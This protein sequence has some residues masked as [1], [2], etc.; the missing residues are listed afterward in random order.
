MEILSA[1]IILNE[2]NIKRVFI[3]VFVASK[4]IIIENVNA[5]NAIAIFFP[6]FVNIACSADG[7]QVTFA[8]A[9]NSDCVVARITSL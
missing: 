3:S 7:W 4:I 5:I 2:A 6:T 8:I 9:R 1:I